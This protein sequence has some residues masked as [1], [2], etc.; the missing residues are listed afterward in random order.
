MTSTSPSDLHWTALWQAGVLH[1]CNSAIQGN[2][3]GQI[4]EFWK[5][6]FQMLHP[7]QQV[8]DLGTGNGA[9]LL[10]AKTTTPGLILHGIDSA[11]IDP[12][13]VMGGEKYDYDGICFHAGCQMS[14]LPFGDGSTDLVTSQYAFEYAP[15]QPA[16]AETLR[17]LDP[18]SGRIAMVLH[19]EDSEISR[20]TARQL[21]GLDLL[22][23]DL[24]IFGK[25]RQLATALRS[26]PNGAEQAR[27]KF[28]S[29]ASLL[30]QEL[31]SGT[32][33]PI[34]EKAYALLH[35]ALAQLARSPTTTLDMLD[36]AETHLRHERRRLEDMQKAAYDQG[37]LQ[38]LAGKLQATGMKVQTGELR[39]DGTTMGWT[40]VAH[41][42]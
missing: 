42:E 23:A 13:K 22:F 10:L 26:H 17:I 33:A 28:N 15:M 7:G 39:Q 37:Q 4:R 29:S 36:R 40:L 30:M 3:D 20:M 14:S 19:S 41:H 11:R 16:L 32:H 24:D 18:V 8:V 5:S 27:T 35:G 31:S 38:A 25:A 34:V 2:Y 1:S 21:Q 12:A 6:R 9:L